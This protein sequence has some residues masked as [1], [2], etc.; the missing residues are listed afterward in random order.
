[1][2]RKK[3]AKA[4]EDI[5]SEPSEDDWDD[6]RQGYEIPSRNNENRKTNKKGV[7]FTDPEERLYSR[8]Y[9]RG[10]GPG[11]WMEVDEGWLQEEAEN[12]LASVVRSNAARDGGII[13]QLFNIGPTT[14]S[15]EV[16]DPLGMGVID[17]S[18]LKLVRCCLAS[19]TGCMHA[20]K[21][22][23]L[24]YRLTIQVDEGTSTLKDAEPLVVSFV[25]LVRLPGIK[26]SHVH[27]CCCCN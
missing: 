24:T 14:A 6:Y 26:I 12:L 5:L 13:N 16:H 19:M 18:L 17:L 22:V 15:K 9:D 1:M 10:S 2:P 25:C 27:V 8:T 4:S 23:T 20:C 3:S 11:S 7:R 21:N